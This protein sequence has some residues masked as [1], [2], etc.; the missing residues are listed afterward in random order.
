V[1]NYDAREMPIRLNKSVANAAEEAGQ[2]E[3]RK[4]I[5]DKV[6][7]RLIAQFTGH[8]AQKEAALQHQMATEKRAHQ[9][10]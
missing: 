10:S 9:K 7:S 1:N 4:N 5:K 2:E 6:T 3:M 8:W